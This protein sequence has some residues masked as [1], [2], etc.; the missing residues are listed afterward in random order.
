MGRK[1]F[2]FFSNSRKK[3]KKRKKEP[4]ARG[5]TAVYHRAVSCVIVGDDPKPVI[6]PFSAP[7]RPQTEREGVALSIG[8]WLWSV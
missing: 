5:L 6:G 3:E 1:I 7:I 8:L 4:D 2:I